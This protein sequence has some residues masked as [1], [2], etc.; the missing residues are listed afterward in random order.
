MEGGDDNNNNNGNYYYN[1]NSGGDNYY[2]S[3]YIGPYCASDGKSIHLG[4]Y[5][6]QGCTSHAATSLYATR[7]YGVALP[8]SSEPIVALNECIS[9]IEPDNDNDNDNNN[10][11][12]N[13]YQSYETSALCQ[14]AYE[15]A[16]KCETGM[17]VTYPVTTGCEYIHT[18]L[19]A[20]STASKQIMSG[21][22]SVGTAGAFAWVFAC[23]T[24]LFGAYAYF[25]YRKIKRGGAQQMST[26]GNMA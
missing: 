6:D 15:G 18:I 4:V 2:G 13:N 17:S 25:L 22:T 8:F 14:A 16:V 12:Q 3:L 26:G 20:L 7:N 9:C 10:N 23:T 1:G 5:Y 21:S 19:P 24:A 11:Y